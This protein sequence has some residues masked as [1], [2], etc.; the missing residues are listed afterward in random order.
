MFKIGEFCRRSGVTPRTVRYYEE[1][2]LLRPAARSGKVHK[3]YRTEAIT[4]VKGIKL[5]QDLG[6]CLKDIKR[7]IAL[8]KSRRT[9]NRWLA[10]KLRS[11]LTRQQDGLSRKIRDLQNMNNGIDRLLKETVRCQECA[12]TDCGACS[13]LAKLR[14]AMAL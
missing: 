2:G 6:Y 1:C 4:L 3:Y 5:L 12:S 14:S 10:L 9:A 8:T 7:T 13:C 11:E